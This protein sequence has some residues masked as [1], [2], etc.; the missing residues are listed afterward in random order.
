MYIVILRDLIRVYRFD[1]LSMFLKANRSEDLQDFSEKTSCKTMSKHWQIYTFLNRQL[2]LLRRRC[3]NFKKKKIAKC[4]IELVIFVN[5]RISVVYAND[6]V[7]MKVNQIH[8]DVLSMNVRFVRFALCT[9]DIVAMQINQFQKKIATIKHNT[10]SNVLSL[11]VMRISIL[12]TYDIVKMKVIQFQSDRDDHALTE[13]THDIVEIK[14]NQFQK[15]RDEQ[16]GYAFEH[17]ISMNA[18]ISGLSTYNMV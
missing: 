7:E 5:L 18:R 9:V 2:G 15:D 17:V 14:A 12:S 4:K 8:K 16:T 3:A 10:N 13:F 6:I 11:S 1:I